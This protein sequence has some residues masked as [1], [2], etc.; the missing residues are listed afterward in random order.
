[1]CIMVEAA[2]GEEVA[3]GDQRVAFGQFEFAAGIT[4]KS[5]TSLV[6][7]LGM[8][9]I[10]KSQVSRVCEEIDGKVKAFLERPIEGDWPYLARSRP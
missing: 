2:V 4:T 7:A 10:S 9:G 6:K 5:V 1:M 3:T 8:N